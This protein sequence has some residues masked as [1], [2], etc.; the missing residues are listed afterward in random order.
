MKKNPSF[1]VVNDIFHSTN[2]LKEICCTMDKDPATFLN[3]FLPLRMHPKTKDAI[4]QTI[5]RFKPQSDTVY[6]GLILADQSVVAI[7]KNN[8]KIVVFPAGK[9]YIYVY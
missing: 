4:E 5:K 8:P 6:F 3:S 9:L 2:L 1:D 7:I